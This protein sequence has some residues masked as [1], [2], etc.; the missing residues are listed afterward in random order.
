MISIREDED[1][2]SSSEGNGCGKGQSIS[3]CPRVGESDEF[4]AREPEA[5]GD[6]SWSD[7]ISLLY[8]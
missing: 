1:L 7:N 8:L 3:F 2:L 6:L 5:V 4:D